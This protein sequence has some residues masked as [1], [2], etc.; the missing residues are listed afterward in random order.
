MVMN[1]SALPERL[2]CIPVDQVHI[3]GALALPAN[4]VGIVLFAHGS[5]SSRHSPRNN[6]VARVLH[7]HQLGTLLLDL[8]TP[9]EDLDYSQRFDIPL[10]AARPA[11]KPG[12]DPTPGLEEHHPRSRRITSSSS[13]WSKRW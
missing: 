2:A 3:E 7:S 5:G 8:L 9:E 1:P 6:S 11:L 10:L 4:P 12:P 13:T